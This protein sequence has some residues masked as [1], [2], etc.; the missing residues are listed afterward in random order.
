[1]T[2]QMNTHSEIIQRVTSLY[3]RTEDGLVDMMEFVGLKDLQPPREKITAL[4]IGN[5]SA[6]KSS[7]INW[8][9]GETIQKESVAMETSGFTFV[10]SGHKRDTFK[11]KATQKHME[12]LDGIEN[13]PGLL[14][15]LS[16][17]VSTSTKR[18]FPFVDFVDSPGL[19]DGNLKYPF[20]INEVILFLAE[21]VDLIFV[22]FDPHGQA[23]CD[24]TN[25]VVKSLNKVAKDKMYYFLSKADEVRTQQERTKVMVQLTQSLSRSVA[26]AGNPTFYGEYSLEVRTI[27]RPCLPGEDVG[28]DGDLKDPESTGTGDFNQIDEVVEIID[29]TIK[30]NVQQHCEKLENH[31]KLIL[32]KVDEMLSADATNRSWN[33][34]ASSFSSSLSFV[35]SLLPLL[36]SFYLLRFGEALLPREWKDGDERFAF[37]LAFVRIFSAIPAMVGSSPYRYHILIACV[38]VFFVIQM[39]RRLL[40][41][42][43]KPLRSEEELQKLQRWRASLDDI[44][45]KRGE[46]NHLWEQY[47]GDATLGHD[48]K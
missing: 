22:F 30:Q 24:R 5:H 25:T 37:A 23:T 1:M 27:F 9:I 14:A 17:E 18:R 34:K 40:S 31:S 48:K 42:S 10:T 2:K 29:Q 19:T 47:L 7:F 46:M 35:A 43:I 12:Y 28:E 21:R 6:G 4:I 41:R 20:D 11:G 13:F 33:K 36:L 39:M 15:N 8:Y 44:C 16:T 38:A 3:H 26:D 32:E 45:S